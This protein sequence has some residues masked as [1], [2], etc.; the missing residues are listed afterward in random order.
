MIQR[1][2]AMI[3][4]DVENENETKKVSV[5]L[6][7]NALIM[8][9]YFLCLLGVFLTVGKAP[10]DHAVDV[11]LRIWIGVLYYI[12]ERYETGSIFFG[13]IYHYMDFYFYQ[14][15][16]M[17]LRDTAFYIRPHCAWVYH[18]L[19]QVVMETFDERHRLFIPAFPVCIYQAV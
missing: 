15:V 5:I 17:G 13:V 1:F 2:I 7:L 10:P 18:Q 4:K 16:R 6:R 12:F 9:V 3:F 19:P 8:C 14:T 11:F